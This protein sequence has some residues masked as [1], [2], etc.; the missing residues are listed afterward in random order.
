MVC[1]ATKTQQ[2]STT[3]Q[4][5]YICWWISPIKMVVKS[6]RHL[7]ECHRPHSRRAA[8]HDP[9]RYIMRVTG[10]WV[11]SIAG[12]WVKHGKTII[13]QLFVGIVEKPPTS[14]YGDL[15]RDGLNY[16]FTHIKST[17]G[18]YQLG[19]LLCCH[20]MGNFYNSLAWK[21]KDF[22]RIPSIL[23]L[24]PVRSQVDLFFDP[25]ISKSLK[26]IE[27]PLNK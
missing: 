18:T 21:K 2:P 24:I 15:G 11:I 19:L 7:E 14:I 3:Q 4:N 5:P 6:L 22:G 16:C 9:Y 26:G 25:E 1:S 12:M 13:H 23:T 10:L 8:P 20:Y 27:T 17:S